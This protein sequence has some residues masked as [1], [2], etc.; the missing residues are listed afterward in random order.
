MRLFDIRA[1]AELMK[2]KEESHI[3]GIT[4]SL[5]GRLIF[6]SQENQL[7]RVSDAFTGDK[8]GQ[9]K[10]HTDQVSCLSTSHDGTAIASG[11]WDNSVK[12]SFKL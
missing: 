8:I 11:A 12:V 9:L 2:F 5:S 7:I 6:S 4:C 10:G 3:T 1:N